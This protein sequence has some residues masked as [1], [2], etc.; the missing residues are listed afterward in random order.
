MNIPRPTHRHVPWDAGDRPQHSRSRRASHA[1]SGGW[2]PDS[3]A[4]DG[5]S[6]D[7]PARLSVSRVRDQGYARMRLGPIGVLLAVAA[8]I[9]ALLLHAVRQAPVERAVVHGGPRL[10]QSSGRAHIHADPPLRV[11]LTTH[12]PPGLGGAAAA[13]VA[14]PNPKV[15][16]HVIRAMSERAWRRSPGEVARPRLH[17]SFA[18]LPART[19]SSRAPLA[20]ASPALTEGLDG[21]EPAGSQ[22][23]GAGNAGEEFGFER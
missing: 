16:G 19:S 22:A 20:P 18:P 9:L 1:R 5:K 23:A 10:G 3:S 8:A 2:E 6:S 17:M 15:A 7:S 13:T 4:R 14:R 12:G 21:S 11:R